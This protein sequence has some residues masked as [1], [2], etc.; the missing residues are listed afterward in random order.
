MSSHIRS[1][2]PQTLV[3][4]ASRKQA[5]D[6]F[7][8]RTIEPGRVLGRRRPGGGPPA[9]PSPNFRLGRSSE[10]EVR[11]QRGR[12]GAGGGGRMAEPYAGGRMPPAPEGFDAGAPGADPAAALD[13]RDHVVREKLV[14]VAEA[15][16]RRP[17][18]APPPPGLSLPSFRAF[19]L[20]QTGLGPPVSPAGPGGGVGAGGRRV[21]S[22]GCQ[23]C[24]RSTPGRSPA[25]PRPL[26]PPPD[27]CRPPPTPPP[28]PFP[29]P[30][31]RFMC[32][33]ILLGGERLT[34]GRRVAST[35]RDQGVLPHRGGEPLQEL[36]GACR[37][38]RAHHPEHW[39]TKV[40]CWAMGQ[41][42]RR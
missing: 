7:F 24:L 12:K 3:R 42:P 38:V 8:P 30:P 40:Q 33:L 29:R 1:S 18:P 23:P 20:G 19:R 2:Q 41:R 9:S 28:F 35:G 14:K 21:R 36:P 17:P 15:R 13:Q 11:G 27:P 22:V 34:P 37:R 10:A 26:S 4:S 31:P 32:Q 16:V 25:L 5:I 39:R 6:D